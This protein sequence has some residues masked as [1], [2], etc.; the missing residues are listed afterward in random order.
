MTVWRHSTAMRRAG[1]LAML[2]LAALLAGC[3]ITAPKSNAGYADLDSLG[4]FDTDRVVSISIGPSLLRFAARYM[5]DDPQTRAL[6]RSLE[7][8]RVKVYEVTGDASDISAR[9]ERMSERLLSDHWQAVMLVHEQGELTQMLMKTEQDRISGLVV[10]SLEAEEAVLINVM[11]DLRPELFAN[12]MA[13]LDVDHA[14]DVEIAMSPA[15][16]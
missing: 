7:G 11:G 9:M 3:G 2:G 14:P 16:G 8:V 1:T 5:D 4:M 12:T 13:A 10:M 6:L 15:G